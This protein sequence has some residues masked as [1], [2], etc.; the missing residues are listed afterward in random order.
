MV[1]LSLGDQSIRN[2]VKHL[3]NGSAKEAASQ[4]RRFG[5][6][7]SYATPGLFYVGD[8]RSENVCNYRSAM[9]KKKRG[10]QF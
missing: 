9:V 1:V 7:Y 3:A 2:Q 6:D 10:L 4:I 5:G 8:K